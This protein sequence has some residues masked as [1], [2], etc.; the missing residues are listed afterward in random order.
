[1]TYTFP[2]L[3]LFKKKR[4][5]PYV[6]LIKQAW[7]PNNKGGSKRG[8]TYIACYCKL[9]QYNIYICELSILFSFIICKSASCT[10]ELVTT[11]SEP[12]VLTGKH[13]ITHLLA[14][15]KTS[16]GSQ[17]W[18]KY[19]FLTLK[20]SKID[21][22]LICCLTVNCFVNA[23]DDGKVMNYKV[24]LN[25]TFRQDNKPQ[26][27]TNFHL[28]NERKLNANLSI[29]HRTISAFIWI[30]ISFRF[31]LNSLALAHPPPR[32]LFLGK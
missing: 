5:T 13:N 30:H 24:A 4:I 26:T 18:Q 15:W 17:S 29:Q 31:V 27:L 11:V 12:I 7:S 22:W 14:C 25:E 21:C 28:M 2:F 9:L 3:P 8:S 32:V 19:T 1:M 23:T 16:G 6:I 20:G 10:E